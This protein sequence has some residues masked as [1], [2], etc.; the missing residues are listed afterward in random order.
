MP[1][2]KDG[3]L[4]AEELRKV[5]GIPSHRRLRQGPCAVIECAQLIPLRPV[6]LI[7]VPFLGIGKNS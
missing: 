4:S 6:T 7:L 2:E 1:L 3:E 5:P